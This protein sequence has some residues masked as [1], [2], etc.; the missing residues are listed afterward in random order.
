MQD[1]HENK[2][3]EIEL[4]KSQLSKTILFEEYDRSRKDCDYLKQQLI[5]A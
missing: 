4:L 3:R 1:N 5:E 2:I